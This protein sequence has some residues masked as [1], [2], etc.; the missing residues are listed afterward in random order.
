MTDYSEHP[1]NSEMT[2]K[3]VDGVFRFLLTLVAVIA[4][5]ALFGLMGFWSFIISVPAAVIY[6][7]IVDDAFHGPPNFKDNYSGDPPLHI[8]YG[9]DDDSPDPS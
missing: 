8:L 6:L 7:G 3:I 5:A 9:E 4:A 2:D 1:V